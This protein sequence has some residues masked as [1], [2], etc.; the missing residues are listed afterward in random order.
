M[1]PRVCVVVPVFNR[2]ELTKQ[3]L[4]YFLQSTYKNYQIVIVDDGSTDGTSEYLQ[5]NHPEVKVLSG[6]GNLWWT[7]ATNKGVEYALQNDFDYVLTINQDAVVQPDYLQ[8]FVDCAVAKPDAIWGNVILDE[9][10][11][12][13]WAFGVTPKW[14]YGIT[15]RQP[16]HS[17]FEHNFWQQD[18][19]DVLQKIEQPYAVDALNGDGVLIPT[20]VYKQIGLYNF[21]WTPQYHA[22]TEFCLRAKR[23]G[24][25]IYICTSARI[26]NE[27]VTTRKFSPIER[28]FSYRSALHWRP[29][30][31]LYWSYAPLLMKPFFFWVYLYYILRL[32]LKF[33]RKGK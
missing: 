21:E 19:E 17:L 28:V 30:F 27:D 25:E 23:A 1:Q 8:K 24:I 4:G 2:L 33:F 18:L 6:D 31:K 14:A 9:H 32:P 3:F 29:V 26:T 10:T 7:G 13:V 16:K 12:K 5:D 20:N 22:D 11:G 15:P